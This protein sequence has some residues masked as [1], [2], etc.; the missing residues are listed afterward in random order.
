MQ[1]LAA[2]ANDG[3]NVFGST[4]VVFASLDE[5][6]TRAL[7][8]EVPRAYDTR[9]DDVLLTA[10]VRAVTTWTGSSS[11]FVELEGHGREGIVD[12]VDLSR[13]VG[14]CTTQYPAFL[15]LTGVATPR[16]ALRSIKEQLRAVP[17]RGIGYGLLRYMS[18]DAQVVATMRSLPRPDVNF[19]YLGQFD[20]L[21]SSTGTFR[22]L[23]ESAGSPC[24]S[25]VLRAHLLEVV[26]L[27]SDGRLRMRFEYSDRRHRSSTIE[28]LAQ[29]Y[30]AEL[31]TLIEHCQTSDAD[32]LKP[33][34]FLKRA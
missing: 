4:Q 32:G 19:L 2:D 8:R 6:Q 30:T 26:A 34:D 7:L 15:D 25:E 10:L 29:V 13:T 22:P 9:I 23:H 14:W 28:A 11:L 3:D 31:T 33:S 24:S 5:P 18:T 12:G 20:P 17:C 27:V 1:A 16:E 21:R